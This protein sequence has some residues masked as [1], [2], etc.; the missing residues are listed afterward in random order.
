M[1][2]ENEES[3]KIV[4]Q[5]LLAT[6]AQAVVVVLAGLNLALKFPAHSVGSLDF[7]H[8][9]EIFAM[10]V[11][12]PATVVITFNV[13]WILER[14]HRDDAKRPITIFMV[15]VCLLGISMGV[16]EPIYTLPYSYPQLVPTLNFWD[17]FFSHIIF[18]LSY[19]GGSLSLLWSQAR[20]PLPVA[21]SRKN[22]VVFTCIAIMAGVGIFLTLVR[23][24]CIRVDLII[25]A[26]VLIAAEWLRKGKSMR[27]LPIALAIEGAYFLA[28][29][30]LLVQRLLVG[31]L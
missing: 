7:V 26:L 4:R 20:N 19:I 18:Y 9:R 15:S 14:G 11:V 6:L 23:G 5:L 17:E 1:L 29:L 12:L 3:E 25:I 27:Y 22:T 31:R 30:G 21:M 16:H 10:L 24:G 13:I 28:F 2:S 8:W